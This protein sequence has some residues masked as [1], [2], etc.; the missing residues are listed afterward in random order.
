[1]NSLPNEVLRMILS[2]L[3]LEQ[4]FIIERT[5]KIFRYLNLTFPFKRDFRIR[6]RKRPNGKSY[7]EY[8]V[9]DKETKK[10]YTTGIK[11][12][13][14]GTATKRNNTRGVR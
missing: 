6:N 4:R 7:I 12:I 13:K 9:I 8:V 2:N 5:C 14:D 3:D 10:I 11:R 1:M